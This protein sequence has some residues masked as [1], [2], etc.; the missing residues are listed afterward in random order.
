M[1]HCNIYRDNFVL[2]TDV[3]IFTSNS[4]IASYSLQAMDRC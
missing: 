1:M 2:E 4:E 3:E